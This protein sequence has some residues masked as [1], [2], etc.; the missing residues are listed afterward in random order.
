M[1]ID[2]RLS[3]SVF[4]FTHPGKGATNLSHSAIIHF[5]VS[6]HAPWEGCDVAVRLVD[7][8]ISKVSI[9]APWEGCDT[10]AVTYSSLGRSF[11]SRTL[12][13]VR[14]M[15]YLHSTYAQ[16]F[17][18][19]T[20]GRVRLWRNTC[21]IKAVTF[22]FT[23]P[24]KGATQPNWVKPINII[25]SIHAPWEGCDTLSSSRINGRTSV[26]IHAPWEGCDQVVGVFVTPV[27][28]FNSRTLGRVRLT[29]EQTN[30]NN[31]MFQFTH[32]GKGATYP[33]ETTVAYT[34]RFN[35]RTLGRVRLQL[36]HVWEHHL[37]VSIHAP[38]EGCDID[39]SW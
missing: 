39:L 27:V 22:Q 30:N 38:W 34:E 18:S 5:R 21:V 26:S 24:G 28:S 4:Q 9:H 23:H 17:N 12:G 10:L 3:E 33:R 37:Q 25:V 36:L 19:R 14:H 15:H 13:R 29:M 20:L 11:N 6:I 8:R 31:K 32:P 7:E 16:R 1:W 2:S 35:S